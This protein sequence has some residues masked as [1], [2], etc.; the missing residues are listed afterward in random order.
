M[1]TTFI[2]MLI[3]N[4]CLK[5]FLTGQVVDGLLKN[6]LFKIKSTWDIKY[7][8]VSLQLHNFKDHKYFHGKK[9]L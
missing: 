5:I 2:N 8:T 1:P 6:S 7:S 3:L 9:H 4:Q